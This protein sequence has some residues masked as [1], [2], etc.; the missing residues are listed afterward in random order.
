MV[1]V[2]YSLRPE[3]LNRVVWR[4]IINMAHEDN[5][6]ITK[7]IQVW[8]MPPSWRA[9]IEDFQLQASHSPQESTKRP[10]YTI[11]EVPRRN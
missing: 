7:E 3:V 9:S 1:H 11:T 10:I 6:S 4:L 5:P 8:R 2:W